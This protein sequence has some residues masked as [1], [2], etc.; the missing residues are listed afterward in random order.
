M[1]CSLTA[2]AQGDRA[3]AGE[4]MRAHIAVTE[5][6]VTAALSAQGVAAD[7]LPG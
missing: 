5:Q 6:A 7:R 4:V 3:G 1:A 2:C